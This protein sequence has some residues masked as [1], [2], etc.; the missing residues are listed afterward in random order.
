MCNKYQTNLLLGLLA[1]S[2]K[3]YKTCYFVVV[4]TTNDN[5]APRYSYVYFP[6]AIV[7]AGT[8][9]GA[10]SNPRYMSLKTM[11]GDRTGKVGSSNVDLYKHICL[12]WY[13]HVCIG[14]NMHELLQT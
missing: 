13:K 5:A 3:L 7:P 12:Y 8:S 1:V 11:S 10:E 2:L 6:S 14:T 9:D 4:G